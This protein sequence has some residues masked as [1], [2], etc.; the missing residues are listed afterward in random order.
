MTNKPN[1]LIIHTDQ[2]SAWTLGIYGGN[3]VDTPNIDNI[4]HKG[5]VFNNFF[6]NSA[7]CTPSRGCFVTGRYPHCHGAYNNELEL[8]RNETTIAHVLS[9]NGYDTGYIGKWHLDGKWNFKGVSDDT[10]DKWIAKERS[11]GFEDSTY[12][13]NRGHRKSVIEK[14]DG[15]PPFRSLEIGDEKTYMTDWLTTKSIEFMDRPREKPFF[16]MLSI[17]DPHMPYTVREPYSSMFNPEDLPLPETFHQEDRPGW[18]ENS[19]CNIRKRGWDES[20][21]RKIKSQYLG[22]VKCIDDNVGRIMEFLTNKNILD[23]TIIVYTTDHGDYMGE[24]GLFAKDEL[25]ETASRIP[26]LMKW[27][28]KIKE[29]TVIDN[30]VS[31][32]DFQPTILGLMGIESCGR[33]QGHDASP[34]ITGKCTDWEDVAYIHHYSLEKVGIFT[35][36]YQLGLIKQGEHIL[37]DRKND[38][39]QINNLFDNDKYKEVRNDLIRKIV[40]HN[41]EVN[42]PELTWLKDVEKE[43]TG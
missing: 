36:E 38:P 18:L 43:F 22:E 21:I 1:L 6:A 37:F 32:V 28:E 19:Q 26:M 34:L 20:Y 15:S 3:I 42:A 23:D 8:N 10:P 41:N 5:A 12:M 17:P 35:R 30:V 4:G 9:K 40:D 24:H 13:F 39:L 33:E 11:M 7:V 25:Y 29:G 2:Q 27:P 14:D 31:N 16:L